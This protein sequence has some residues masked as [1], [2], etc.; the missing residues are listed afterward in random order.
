MNVIFFSP[1]PIVKDKSEQ[2]AS[3][4]LHQYKHMILTSAVLK[5]LYT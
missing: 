2:P 3:N 5:A 1:I 4:T